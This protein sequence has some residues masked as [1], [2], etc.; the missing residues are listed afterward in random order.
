MQAIRTQYK[1]PTNSGPSKMIA[2]HDGGKFKASYD[3]GLSGSDNHARAAASL[4]AKLGWSGT[5]VGGSLPDGSM[6]WVFTTGI[7]I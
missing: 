1:G 6:A 3:H 5:M 7:K 4:K 2:E